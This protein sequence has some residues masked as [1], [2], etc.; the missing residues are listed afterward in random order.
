M[1]VTLL[2]L[3]SSLINSF[4]AHQFI[5][6]P[7]IPMHAVAILISGKSVDTSA[8]DMQ[9]PTLHHLSLFAHCPH[10]V[11]STLLLIHSSPII[12]SFCLQLNTMAWLA[13][14]A[15]TCHLMAHHTLDLT[16]AFVYYT[17]SLLP[18]IRKQRK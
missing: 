16:T 17:V 2:L 12:S 8:S 13:G 7:S 1:V 11:G 6:P 18:L 15:G 14:T 3:P 9:R 5:K 10:K 4:C